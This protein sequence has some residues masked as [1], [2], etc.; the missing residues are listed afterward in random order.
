[1]GMMAPRA[2][3]YYGIRVCKSNISCSSH[4]TKRCSLNN[5][6]N[7]K[8][9]QQWRTLITKTRDTDGVSTQHQFRRNVFTLHIP[10]PRNL[11]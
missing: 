11:T 6:P 1:M 10:R 5:V 3:I 8:C 7:S 9:T 4:D 2:Q